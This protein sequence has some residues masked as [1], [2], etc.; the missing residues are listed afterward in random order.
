MI[1]DEEFQLFKVLVER[2]D[3]SFDGHLTV[4]KF[5]TNWRVSFLAPGDRDDVHDMHEGKTLGEAA[6][7]ALDQV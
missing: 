6:R 3:N 7:K 1:T 4:M 2:A 5:T